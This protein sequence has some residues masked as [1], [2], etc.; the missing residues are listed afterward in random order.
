MQTQKI[1]EPTF[2]GKVFI[3]KQNQGGLG[4]RH[5]EAEREREKEVNKNRTAVFKSSDSHCCCGVRWE[6]EGVF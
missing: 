2:Y 6:D 1:T 5:R 3:F 4:E